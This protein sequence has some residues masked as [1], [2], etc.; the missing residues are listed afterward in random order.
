MSEALFDPGTLRKLEQLSIV[1][2]QVRE[3][4]IK[5]ERRSKRRGTSVEF[6]DYR[7]YTRGDDLRRVDWNI[8]ARLEKPFIKLLEE[9]EDLATHFLVDASA[10]MNWHPEGK[11]GERKFVWGMRV[12][13]GLAYVS[14]VSGDQVTITALQG[15]HNITW[16]PHRGRAFLLPLLKHLEKIR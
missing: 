6:A 15:E 2:S 4:A 5:G 9:E 11:F 8:Y 3:G 1:A 16:G 13:A 12:M 10:S 7:D 14:L